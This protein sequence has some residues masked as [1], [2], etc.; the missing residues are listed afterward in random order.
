MARSD[1]IGGNAV[2]AFWCIAAYRLIAASRFGDRSLHF[3]AGERGGVFTRFTLFSYT[4][5]CTA[6]MRRSPWKAI[7]SGAHP[8][9]YALLI[10]V[11]LP[12]PATV[13]EMDK[14]TVNGLDDDPTTSGLA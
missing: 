10:D 4:S 8:F 13:A 7:A 1:I 9:G 14:P 5:A 12:I 3:L 6:K 2:G 11:T